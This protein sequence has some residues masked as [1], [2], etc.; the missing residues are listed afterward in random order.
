LYL[1][2]GL[3]VNWQYQHNTMH[4][5]YTNIEGYDEDIDPLFLMR[6]SPHKKL[7]KIHR[8]QFI[9]A[10]FL[11]GLMTLSWSTNKDFSQLR[12]YKLTE[13]KLNTGKTYNQ[14]LFD[15]ILSKILY[16]IIFLGLPMLLISQPWYL[17]IVAFFVMHFTSGII[18]AVIFQTAHVVTSTNFP[19]PDENGRIDNNWAIHQLQTTADFSPN[20]RVFS[21][22]I[23][24]LNYQVEH[25]LFPNICHVHYRNISKLV[26]ATANKYNL[27]YNQQGSFI[28]AVYNHIQMLRNLGRKEIL[29]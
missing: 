20:S 3:P 25:H 10:W 1:L 12:T 5:G 21:W 14:L 2:G 6:F 29:Q 26:K 16:Y 7:L 22:F 11:Y 9:Y 17:I 18:L 8:F 24:G 4:H 28:S 23:G 15:L 13:A 19:L 27:P